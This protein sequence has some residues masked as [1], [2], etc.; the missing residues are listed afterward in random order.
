MYEKVDYRTRRQE[1]EVWVDS[2]S[3]IKQDDSWAFSWALIHKGRNLEKQHEAW[4]IG[5]SVKNS[6]NDISSEKNGET[7]YLEKFL[8][9]HS[10]LFYYSLFITHAKKSN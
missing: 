8:I 4:W 5:L 9:N 2:R 1:A 7:Y 6:L 10:F 3:S